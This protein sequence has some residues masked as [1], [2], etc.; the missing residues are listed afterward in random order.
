MAKRR[1][2][3]P[4]PQAKPP[5]FRPFANLEALKAVQP[6]PPKEAPPPPPPKKAETHGA[7]DS[8]SFHRLM[9]G[10]TPLDDSQAERIT[11]SR[12]DKRE[13]LAA[14]QVREEAR[15]EAEAAREHL[16]QLVS[17]GVR[18]EVQDDG[19]RVEGRRLDVQPEVLRKLRR[20]AFPVDAKLDLHGLSSSEAH[21]AVA[22]FLAEKRARHERCVLIVHGKGTHSVG[23]V[24]ILR[25][26]IG[27]WLSQGPASHHVAAFSSATADDGGAGAVYVLLRP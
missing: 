24:G 18:F 9:S 26:E 21:A 2:P 20:G 16:R 4:E 14:D 22:R 1:A 6:S 27:A 13:R 7:D 10:V 8:L 25:G 19:D 11:K 17:D 15:K 12:V 3:K 5:V 23:G